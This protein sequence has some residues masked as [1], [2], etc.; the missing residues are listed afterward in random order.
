MSVLRDLDKRDAE[1]VA[2]MI[3]AALIVHTLRASTNITT[4]AVI[5]A[6][7]AHNGVPYRITH[8]TKG[9]H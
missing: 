2:N 9:T 3:L 5:N 6:A 4:P 1:A 8:A 7:M